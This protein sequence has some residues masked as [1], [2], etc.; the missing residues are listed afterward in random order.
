MRLTSEFAIDKN[1]I[2]EASAP[3]FQKVQ[4]CPINPLQHGT[5]LRQ[6]LI[7]EVTIK[8]NSSMAQFEE[9]N[10]G[11][12]LITEDDFIADATEENEIESSIDHANVGTESLTTAKDAAW[13]PVPNHHHTQSPIV[14]LSKA[15]VSVV[16]IG[17]EADDMATGLKSQGCIYNQTLCPSNSQVRVKEYD[18]HHRLAQLLPVNTLGN[19][20]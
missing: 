10:A 18:I 7:R 1:E 6:E 9:G 17:D 20:K 16:V 13:E 8:D 3:S 15:M 12:D 4:R 11:R 14:C 2:S 19:V 5:S